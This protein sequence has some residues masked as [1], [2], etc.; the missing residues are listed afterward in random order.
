MHSC[1]SVDAFDR[2][3]EKYPKHG[4]NLAGKKAFPIII[5]LFYS[6]L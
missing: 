5:I 6:P 2:N 4:R 1:D 3:C